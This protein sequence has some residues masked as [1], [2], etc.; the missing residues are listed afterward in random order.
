ML[1]NKCMFVPSVKYTRNETGQIVLS[2]SITVM[3]EM[4]VNEV[5]QTPFLTYQ[6]I[7]FLLEMLLLI[8]LTGLCIQCKFTIL[9]TAHTICYILGYHT[10]CPL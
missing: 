1:V 10:L 6:I 2:C 3:H 9:A 7:L 8:F 4:Q 5:G